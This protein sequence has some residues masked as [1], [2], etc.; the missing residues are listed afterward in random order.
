MHRRESACGVAMGGAVGSRAVPCCPLC[1]TVSHALRSKEC[2]ASIWHLIGIS[3]A[4]HRYLAPPPAGARRLHV[5]QRG[6]L[7]PS[8]QPPPRHTPRG[9]VAPSR[10]VPR[11]ASRRVQIDER[12]VRRTAL[13]TDMASSVQ[14]S[15]ISRPSRFKSTRGWSV[16]RP[17]RPTW[18]ARRPSW[19]P[20]A[21]PPR[22]APGVW[23]GQG[24]V[25][26]GCE[27]CEGWAPGV[28]DGQG[29]AAAGVV[30]GGH[31]GG[32]S[33]RAVFTRG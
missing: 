8:S 7:S 30:C 12:L 22:W 16:A 14:I 2:L 27:G 6:I 25:K 28:S 11:P 31:T 10:A 15:A 33:P 9:A 5:G 24:R 32:G 20:A 1:N 13:S 26:G 21:S 23:D 29:V 18:P 19:R 3:S 4:S 17:S